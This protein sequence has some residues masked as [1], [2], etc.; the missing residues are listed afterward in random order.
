[1][2]EIRDIFSY[3]PPDRGISIA[4]GRF[5]GVHVGHQVLIKNAV[6]EGLKA[7][8]ETVCFSFREETYIGHGPNECLTTD[9]E[10]LALMEDLGIQTVLH[11]AFAP[12]LA[13]TPADVFV[14][15]FL[16]DSWKARCMT[17]GYDFHFG[18][19]RSG[20]SQ[21]LKSLAEN[22]GV[23][24]RIISPVTVDGEIVKATAIRGY[25][26]EGNIERAGLLLGRPYS[27]GA[28][29]VSGQHLGTEIGYPTINLDWPMS[30]VMAPFGVYAVRL[31]SDEQSA[32]VD[33]VASFGVRPTVEEGR[34]EPILEV[35][36]LDPEEVPSG[37]S[38]T[39]E[40]HGFIRREERFESLDKLKEQIA[41]DCDA[42]KE[43]LN[44][45]RGSMA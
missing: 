40:F 13:D 9:L 5:D 29:Q 34:K 19:S 22:R 8:L 30:K 27:I 38:F 16:I 23:E 12:P 35:H 39:V 3:T 10:K 36:V 33:A 26:R 7:R 31:R 44:S 2:Q 43:I 25:I 20:D 28:P 17:V 21:F 24:V 42:A 11:P 41:R 4:L 37:T 1:M 18:K 6:A 45:L 15:S 32:A 14:C